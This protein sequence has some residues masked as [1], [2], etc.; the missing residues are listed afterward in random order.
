MSDTK[1]D[2]FKEIN[3]VID[4]SGKHKIRHFTLVYFFVV[5]VICEKHTSMKHCTSILTCISLYIEDLIFIY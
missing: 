3:L 1:F 5:L 4:S 2:V